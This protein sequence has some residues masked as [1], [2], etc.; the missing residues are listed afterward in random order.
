[1]LDVWPPLPIEIKCFSVDLQVEDNIIAALEHPNR[2]RTIWFGRVWTPLERF[3]A[4]TQEPFPEMDLLYLQIEGTV[5]TLPDTFLG[6]S[7]PRL[8]SLHLTHVPFPTLPRLLLSCNDLVDLHL[9]QIPH[10]GYIP[11]EAMATSISALTSLTKLSIGFE[12][13]ASRPDPITRRPP[14][15][16]RAVLP[17]LTKF[18][19]H[20]VSEYLEDLMAQIYAPLL[21]T[22][23]I[24]FFNQ[25]VFSIQQL[26]QSIGHPPTIMERNIA[27][28]FTYMDRVV[29]TFSSRRPYDDL[30]FQISCRGVDWQVSSV[31]QLCNQLSGSFITSSIEIL[32]IHESSGMS[33][34]T[35][36][37]IMDE[38]QWL[39]LFHPFTAVRSLNI[40]ISQA[41]QSHVVSALRGLSGELALQVLPALEELCV[42]GYQESGSE[43]HDMWPF[44]IARRSSDHPVVVI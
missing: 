42:P 2:V 28:I 30:S 4:V 1:M 44:I 31:A 32:N 33:P 39:E 41:M 10:S 18:H 24:I 3:V 40:S 20:G 34:S 11:P 8:R 15:L 26:P 5:P 13:P 37:D 25:L 23:R 14:P 17:A 7:A 22:A 35:L 9:L 12:S 16:I 43:R 38:A 19:F 29:M 21:H 36:E 27:N 6:R